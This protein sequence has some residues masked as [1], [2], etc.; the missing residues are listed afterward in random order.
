M[1]QFECEDAEYGLEE[2]EKLSCVSSVVTAFF[3]TKPLPASYWKI[4]SGKVYQ[5]RQAPSLV[6]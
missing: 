2:A 3:Q 5:K 4:Q 6:N 1:A